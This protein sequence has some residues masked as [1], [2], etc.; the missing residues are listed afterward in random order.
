LHVL[1]ALASLCLLYAFCPPDEKSA[2]R[3]VHGLGRN[4]Y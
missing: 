4:A 1:T 3:E 2:K